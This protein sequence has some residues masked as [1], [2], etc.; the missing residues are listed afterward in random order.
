[1]AGKCSSESGPRLS[2]R[3]FGKQA[4]WAGLGAALAGTPAAARAPAQDEGSHQNGGESE[5]RYQAIIRRYGKR[6]S[7]EQRKRLR[8]ILDYNEKL[9]APVRTFPLE[10][11]QPAATVLK[12][13]E[14]AAAAPHAA[15]GHG[16]A[17]RRK[18][19]A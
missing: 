3:Q 14:D 18:T 1:M 8:K 5:A 12:F 9:L 17:S 2:R 13:Y 15:K 19:K 4:A 6:L 16:R 10:N 7:E 11:G